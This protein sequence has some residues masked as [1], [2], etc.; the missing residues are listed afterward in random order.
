MLWTKK[1]IRKLCWLLQYVSNTSCLSLGKIDSPKNDEVSPNVEIE[2]SAKAKRTRKSAKKDKT[3][4]L[5]DDISANP[6]DDLQY[7]K[8]QTSLDASA[9]P[10]PMK[11]LRRRRRVRKATEND[12]KCKFYRLF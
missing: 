1:C 7:D 9:Q 4:L 11:T 8:Q 2:A 6:Q 10:V 3:H 5:S 12:E